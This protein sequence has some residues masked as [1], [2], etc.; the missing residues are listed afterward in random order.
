MLLV[1]HKEELKVVVFLFTEY[2]KENHPLKLKGDKIG[3]KILADTNGVKNRSLVLEF[4]AIFL[5][6]V[7]V[8]TKLL[9]E[10]NEINNFLVLKP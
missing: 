7:S 5:C 3:L 8:N 9:F 2:L 4:V 6:Q 10:K 1:V